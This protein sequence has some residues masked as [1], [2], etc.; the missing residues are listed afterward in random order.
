MSW[1]TRQGHAK[2][3]E[4]PFVHSAVAIVNRESLTQ[5]ISMRVFAIAASFLFLLAVLGLVIA[6][7]TG[8]LSSRG[9]KIQEVFLEQEGDKIAAKPEKK[10]S[11]R[12]RPKTIK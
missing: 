12:P 11:H 7:W 5:E 10:L 6:N 1:A 4:G 8:A 2:L 3:T 9:A